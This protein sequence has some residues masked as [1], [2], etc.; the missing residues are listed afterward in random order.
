MRRV[1]LTG[2]WRDY[3]RAIWMAMIGVAVAI[4]VNPWAISIFFFGAAVG[5]AA[6]VRRRRRAQAA[7]EDPP[8]RK[9]LRRR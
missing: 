5:L 3:R 4:L 9:R 1:A 7:L 2:D 8:R 6:A